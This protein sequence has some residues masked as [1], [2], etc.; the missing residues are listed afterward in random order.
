M[1]RPPRVLA[2]GAQHGPRLH[3]G[4]P[5]VQDPG[6]SPRPAPTA[7]TVWP[8]VTASRDRPA[9][10]LPSSPGQRPA[11]SVHWGRSRE[12]KGQRLHAGARP[13]L[14]PSATCSQAEARCTSCQLPV[15]R[16][17]RFGEAAA[18]RRSQSKSHGREVCTEAA[19]SESSRARRAGWC[20]RAPP[21]GGSPSTPPASSPQLSRGGVSPPSSSS[22][23]NG[24]LPVRTAKEVGGTPRRPEGLGRAQQPVGTR[25]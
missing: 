24:R 7:P 22:H 10:S 21:H 13:A 4:G 23:R 18:A 15:T 5:S 2:C 6:A 17:P 3:Q 19:R 14:A 11:G 20:R 1:A 8:E 9:L 16:R 12:T 25:V